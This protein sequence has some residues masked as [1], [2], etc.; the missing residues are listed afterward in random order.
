MYHYFLS[1]EFENEA[2]EIQVSNYCEKH[3]RFH[4]IYR[5]SIL[6]FDEVFYL[7]KIIALQLKTSLT[8]LQVT[9]KYFIG[10]ENMN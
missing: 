4:Q 3:D 5:L 1:F 2:H 9:W 6:V 8:P 10:L 7:K